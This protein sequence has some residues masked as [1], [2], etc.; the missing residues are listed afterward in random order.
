MRSMRILER[1]KQVLAGFVIDYGEDLR[2]YFFGIERRNRNGADV[3]RQ[4]VASL[5]GQTLEVEAKVRQARGPLLAQINA[6]WSGLE[7]DLNSVSG[8]GDSGVEIG[9]LGSKSL[10]SESLDK[11]IP[12]FDILIGVSLMLGLLTRLSCALAV[13]FLAGVIAAQWPGAVGAAPTWAQF[14]EALALVHLGV[15]GAGKYGG[16][17]NPLWALCSK[18]CRSKRGT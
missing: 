6:M 13:A 3:A 17:D 15:I 18:C 16:L 2:E 4:N 11:I 7:R 1:Y 5:R 12:W 9:R 8:Q 10:D 14:I